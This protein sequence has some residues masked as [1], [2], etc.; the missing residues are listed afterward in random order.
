MAGTPGAE[1]APRD[2]VA[3]AIWLR[4][5]QGHRVFLD[6]RAA[7]GAQFQQRFPIICGGLPRGRR[8]SGARADPRQ[9]RAALPYGRRGRG[10]ARDAAPSR[11]SGSAARLLHRP[12]RREP[13]GEQLADRGRRVRRC[14]R[15]VDRGR[16]AR[17]P[18]AASRASSRPARSRSRRRASA[19]VVCGGGHA[20]RRDAARGCRAAGSVARSAGPAADPAAV[21]LA[22][23]VSALRREASLG[24]H[25]RI[26]FPERP[27]EPRRSRITLDEALAE[28][29]AIAPDKLTKRA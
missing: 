16:A 18:R 24:A 29:A 2:V 12:A 23:V 11:G 28:A 4:R 27:A 14:R 5:T 8:R 20:G 7:I 1:L 3:R 26:D 15:P 9:A 6:A 22:I 19:P 10:R 21:A 25:C 17:A 13:P